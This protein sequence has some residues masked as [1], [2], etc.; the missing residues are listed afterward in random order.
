MRRDL[1]IVACAISAG[2]HAALAPDHS[3]ESAAMGAAFATSAAALAV[4][5]VL[6]TIEVTAEALATT[7][8]LFAALIVGYLLAVTTGL[9]VLHPDREPVDGI[10]LFTKAVELAGLVAAVDLIRRRHVSRPIPIGLTALIGTF[11]ALVALSLSGAPHVH[12]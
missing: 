5:A 4:L 1:V 10:A 12:G 2:I 6:L 3:A 11:S 7:A 8:G 9:P